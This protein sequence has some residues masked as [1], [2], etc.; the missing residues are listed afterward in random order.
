M[1][2]DCFVMSFV[3]SCTASD[4]CLRKEMQLDSWLILFRERLL[5]CILCF[6]W[7]TQK[8]ERNTLGCVSWF[9]PFIISGDS[10]LEMPMGKTWLRLYQVVALA[11]FRPRD[12]KFSLPGSD[13]QS[14]CLYRMVI[15]HIMGWDWQIIL[16]RKA[17]SAPSFYRQ[18]DQSIHTEKQTVQDITTLKKWSYTMYVLPQIW[19][20][21]Q[22]PLRHQI[23]NVT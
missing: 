18:K 22:P 11:V 6:L 4:L 9:T 14:C 20:I 7:W 21:A 23:K 10:F 1:W 2:E 17:S 3:L 15:Y 12:F 19:E 5:Y 8:N 16:Q 13:C